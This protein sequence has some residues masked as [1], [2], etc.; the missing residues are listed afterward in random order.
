MTKNILP[1]ILSG[2]TGSRLW[3]LSRASYPKQYLKINDQD[4]LSFLQETVKRVTFNKD[5][6]DP[7]IICNEEHRFI[8][9]EQLRNIEVNYKSILLEPFGRNT[10]PAATLAALK[11]M[12]NG[13][14]PNLLVLPSDH[15][16]KNLE[17]FDRVLDS[18]IKYCEGGKLVTFGIM[19]NK[20]ETGYGYIESEEILD[21]K[22]LKGEK[23]LR[24]IEKP[25][26]ELAK[27]FILEKRFSWNSGIFLFKA[28]VF[29][30]EIKKRN[31]DIYQLCK[32]SLSTNLFDLDF[33]RLEKTFFSL[34]PNISIDNAIMEKTDLGVVLPLNAGWSDIGSWQSMWEVSKKNE[35]EN[36]IYGN[37]LANNVSNS[38]L[39]SSERLIV[40]IGLQD[41]IVI[42]T[43]DAILVAKK[44]QDQEVKNIVNYLEEKGKSEANTHKTIYR[45]WGKYTSI[46]SGKNWQVKEIIVKTGE[47]LS[48]QLHKHRTE[49]WI[50]VVGKA[51]VEIN[52]EEK[53]LDKNESTYI[54]IGSKHRLTNI[55]DDH[56]II[57]EV[58]SGHYL[59][60]DDII[61]FQDKYGR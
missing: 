11:A 36:V 34:C 13:Q 21:D 16:F 41:L 2:G 35:S 27:K 18:A 7:I 28:S 48:L 54:P 32:K 4:S 24:F 22:K 58:Q 57:I 20:P 1:V 55:G 23:I 9:A 43:I 42:E 19:P 45:P 33:Q 8:V 59:G 3:P 38:Y 5:V 31:L 25:N 46:A 10:A 56:L 14:D 17:H 37:V 60:E 15:L 52:G 49:H 29:I 44:G 40:G 47:S 61:R 50:N 12:E 39:R 26:K 51:L 30:N 6:D 53:I